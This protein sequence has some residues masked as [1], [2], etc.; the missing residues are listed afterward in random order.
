MRVSLT[1]IVCCF[2]VGNR[3]MKKV[4]FYMNPSVFKYDNSRVLGGSGAFCP[5]RTK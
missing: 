5:R 4:E 2:V 3:F 1:L